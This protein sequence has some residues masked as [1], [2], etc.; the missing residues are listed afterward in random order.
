V[1]LPLDEVQKRLRDVESWSE[2]L[3]GIES[4]RRTSHERYA[5]Q[6]AD[7]R[8]HRELR[9]VVRLRCRDHC[10][11]WHE[12]S[13]PAWRGWLKLSWVADSRTMIT[14][15]LESAPV[16]LLSGMAEWLMPMTS[17][18]VLDLQLLERYLVV[19]AQPQ[20]QPGG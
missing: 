5:F 17:T 12:L 19:A 9:V 3:R 20:L 16:D 2:F 6:L 11:V 13:G 1:S 14:L 15:A 8:D 4:V 10:F 7:G 18:A